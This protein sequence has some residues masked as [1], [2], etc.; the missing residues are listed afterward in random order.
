[1]CNCKHY[2][3]NP[4]YTYTHKESGLELSTNDVH[5]VVEFSANEPIAA[6]VLCRV[7][8]SEYEAEYTYDEFVSHVK[9]L[10]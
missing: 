10:D 5:E 3:T 2:L 1:M 4:F 7:C 9:L 8:D 6:K